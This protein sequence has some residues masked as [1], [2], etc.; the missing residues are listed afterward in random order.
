MNDNVTRIVEFLPTRESSLRELR[1]LLLGEQL[2]QLRRRHHVSRS[3]MAARI[4]VVR[5]DIERI[6]HGKAKGVAEIDAYVRALGGAIHAVRQGNDY[7]VTL[8]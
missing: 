2:A 6:E 5:S 3:T 7:A 1:A 4:G 8:I